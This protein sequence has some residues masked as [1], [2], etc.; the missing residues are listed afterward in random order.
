LVEF[1][2]RL[3]VALVLLQI[4]KMVRGMRLDKTRRTGGARGL[5][6][7]RNTRVDGVPK[8]FSSDISSSFDLAAWLRFGEIR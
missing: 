6:V 4:R 1:R 5:G 2:R 3:P 7:Y 8:L